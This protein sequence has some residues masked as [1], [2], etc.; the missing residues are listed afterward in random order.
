MTVATGL[1]WGRKQVG[2]S[3]VPRG[4]NHVFVWDDYARVW[5]GHFQGNPWCGAFA[6]DV[7][8][9]GGVKLPGQFIS[10]HAAEAW[11]RRH[12][13]F[14]AGING[15]RAGDF[16]ILFGGRHI[17]VAASDAGRNG[18]QSLG[19]NTSSA[20]QWN[21][22]SVAYQ[23]RPRSQVRGY[24][25]LY[26][27]YPKAKPV[28]HAKPKP[29]PAPKGRPV[30]K[31]ANIKPGLKNRDIKVYQLA[32]RRFLKANK[33]NVARLNPSGATG[34]FGRETANMTA[35]ARW[36]LAEKT[37]NQGWVKQP[38]TKASANLVN[39]LGLTPR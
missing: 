16:V 33:Q 22:G 18:Y 2:R 6:L 38:R 26:D 20:N 7:A 32:L 9:H 34:K 30:V 11:G 31:V 27:L 14:H 39:R 4:S 37:K 29:K 21:G 36:I 23:Y 1:A 13:R 28:S 19:G 3:E 12:G 35:A 25:R 24:I 15:M 8:Y 17:E 10:V 5:G